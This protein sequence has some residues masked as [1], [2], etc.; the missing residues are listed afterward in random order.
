LAQ[1]PA[2][3]WSLHV[4][5]SQRPDRSSQTTSVPAVPNRG[6]VAGAVPAGLQVV[7][8]TAVTAH[9]PMPRARTQVSSESQ[10]VSSAHST[11]QSLAFGMQSSCTAH[12]VAGL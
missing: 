3:Q 9:K 12:A 11:V 4:P 10:S 8:P 1:F 7:P 2:W 5:R 6:H